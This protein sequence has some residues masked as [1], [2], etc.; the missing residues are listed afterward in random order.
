MNEDQ[1]KPMSSELKQFVAE[2]PN[3]FEVKLSPEELLAVVSHIQL[4]LKSTQSTNPHYITLARQFGV[5]LQG[6]ISEQFYPTLAYAVMVGWKGG[7]AEG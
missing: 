5:R 3:G 6:K 4:S 1:Q 2:N 7:A